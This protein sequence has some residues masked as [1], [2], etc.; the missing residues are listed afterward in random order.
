MNLLRCP[1]SRARTKRT[2]KE[3]NMAWTRPTIRE[4]CMGMEINGYLPAE[5]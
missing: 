2:K 3:A 5:I 4:I 1:R